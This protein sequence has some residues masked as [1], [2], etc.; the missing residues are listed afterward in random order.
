M[1]NSRDFDRRFNQ[2]QRRFDFMFRVVATIIALVFVG[3]VCFWIF[4]GAL[5]VKAVDQVGEQGVR[6]VVEQLWCGKSPDCKLPL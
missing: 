2:S 4:A 5:A 3:I 6:G 1:F